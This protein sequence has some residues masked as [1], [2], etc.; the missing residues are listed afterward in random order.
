MFVNSKKFHDKFQNLTNHK[1]VNESLYQEAMKILEHRDG[2]N[3][4]DLTIL[5]ARNGDIIVKNVLSLEKGATGLTEKQYKIYKQSLEKKILLHNHPNG[6][7]LS[8]TDL[9]T[10]FDNYD[11]EAS[12]VIGY[13]G[14]VYSATKPNRS[15]NIEKIYK[16]FYNKYKLKYDHND[17]ARV[18][19]LDE[20]YKLG[21]FDYER[22]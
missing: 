14:I 21:I 1:T 16:S 4:E 19:A 9:K 6:G 7:R 10:L 12:I 13:N 15:V 8:F 2:T 17:I 20:L 5:N 3:L 11:I 18:G 22:K